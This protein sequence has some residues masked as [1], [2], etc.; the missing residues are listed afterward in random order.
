MARASL[1]P[2]CNRLHFCTSSL[3]FFASLLDSLRYILSYSSVLLFLHLIIFLLI[4][5]LFCHLLLLFVTLQ[6][7]TVPVYS[8]LYG[9]SASKLSL[10]VESTS[11]INKQYLF[12][13]TTL[14]YFILLLYCTTSICAS[15]S[16]FLFPCSFIRVCFS[17]SRATSQF[18]S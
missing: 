15:S 14:Y 11:V 1:C 13:G 4:F 6:C 3:Q 7:S 17:S 8:T 5:L 9:W 2:C 12:I 16:C 10:I 18:Y